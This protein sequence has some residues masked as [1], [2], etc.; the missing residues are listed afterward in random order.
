VHRCGENETK[1]IVS[2]SILEAILRAQQECVMQRGSRKPAA[3]WAPA[4]RATIGVSSLLPRSVF[5]EQ[6][7]APCHANPQAAQDEA[8]V[9]GRGDVASL[10]P[11]R[12]DRLAQLANRPRS[13]LPTQAYAEAD[14]T[15]QLFQYYLLD[16]SG[17][18]PKVF[19]TLISGVNDKAQLT[20]TGGNCGL[21]TVG[22]ARVVFEPKP[23]L[24][25]DPKDPRA[26]VEFTD[27]SGL[28]VNN[29]ESGWYEGWMIHDL[30][31]P[32]DGSAP[33]GRSTRSSGCC[34][35]RTRTY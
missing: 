26:F 9:R 22:A 6:T 30:T 3:V 24:P 19:T 8:A 2:L 34:S 32:R 21:P 28:F 23:G 20:A 29:N 15:R 25:T 12:Q 1:V 7:P 31:V 33:R 5:A 18:Q 10:P 13:Q 14:G 4:L 16:T 17:F 35:R 11:L 27:L